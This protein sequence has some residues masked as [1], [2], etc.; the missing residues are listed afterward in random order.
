MSF[1]AAIGQSIAVDSREAGKEA[2][3]R[4]LQGLERSEAKAGGKPAVSRVPPVFAWLMVSDTYS[5]ADVLAG[6]NDELGNLPVMGF[7]TSR[8]L[9][10]AGRSRRSVVLV[11]MG[12]AGLQARVGY[13]P[14]FS[15]DARLSVDNLARSLQPNP[16]KREVLLVSADGISGDAAE[17]CRALSEAGGPASG[18]SAAGCL[19]GGEVWRGRT[20][21]AGGRVVGSGALVGAV[22]SGDLVLGQG[23]GHGWLPVGSV[24]RVTR[25]QNNWVRALDGRPVSEVYADLFGVP[26]RDWVRMPLNDL[27]RIYPLGLQETG[28][29]E[30]RSPLRMEVDG[31]LRMSAGILEGRRVEVMIGSADRC[32]QAAADAARQALEALGPARP[33]LAVVLADAAWH[34]LL[35]LEPTAEIEAIR[36]VIGADVPIAGGYT[37]GQITRPEPTGP[38]RLLNQ[39]ILVLLFA[40]ATVEAADVIA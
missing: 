29:L 22:L 3:S 10:S 9:T 20:Y 15:Q 7:S 5:P 11:L 4:A 12:G 17:M 14:E 35:E 19:A 21:Q 8:E 28:G 30:L 39:H 37:F 1:Y 34:A 6:V 16:E 26:A 32:R 25:V 27:V 13:A 36:S 40:A 23:A 2:A 38:V 31:S 18:I 24:S 33:R